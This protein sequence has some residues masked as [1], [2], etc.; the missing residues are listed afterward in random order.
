MQSFNV[1]IIFFSPIIEAAGHEEDIPRVK[2]DV[3]S[4]VIFYRIWYGII[5]NFTF[6]NNNLNLMPYFMEAIAEESVKFMC[7]FFDKIITSI[8]NYGQS[9]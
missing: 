8:Q 7:L 2:D 1:S 4:D 5:K 9:G 6:Y 3:V